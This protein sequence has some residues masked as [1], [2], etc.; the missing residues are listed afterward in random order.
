MEDLLVVA[1]FAWA[2]EEEEFIIEASTKEPT[3]VSTSFK[4]ASS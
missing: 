1:P 2:I 3:V 4:V